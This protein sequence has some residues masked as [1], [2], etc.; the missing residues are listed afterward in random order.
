MARTV[1]L[2][3]LAAAAGIWW[4]ARAYDIEGAEIL[5]YLGGSALFVAGAIVAAVAGALALRFVGRRR[6]RPLLGQ[7][8]QRA[9]RRKRGLKASS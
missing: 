6:R 4:L 8:R 7:P 5:G 3:A 1:V 9:L 2:G